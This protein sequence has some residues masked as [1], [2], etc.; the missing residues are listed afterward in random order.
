MALSPNQVL[1]WLRWQETRNSQPIGS[2]YALASNEDGFRYVGASQDPKKRH[3]SHLN[4][5]N[6]SKFNDPLIE[7]IRSV[8][9]ENV[10]MIILE[11][12]YS[13]KELEEKEQKWIDRML[14][15]DHSLLNKEHVTSYHCA[16][17]KKKVKKKFNPTEYWD[18]VLAP[19][20]G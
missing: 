16:P 10:K 2:V 15:D 20:N 7:W 11:N 13:I 9:H 19:K 18:S 12:C 3:Y 14:L 4:R 5:A 8:G 6:N 17:I 1:A